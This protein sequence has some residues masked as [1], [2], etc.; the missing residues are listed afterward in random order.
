MRETLTK[1]EVVQEIDTQ[2][3][4]ILK[5]KAEFPVRLGEFE[6]EIK[7][8]TAKY[9]EKKKVWDE[10]D[11]AHRQQL[12]A[13]ELNEDRAKR[14][15]EKLEQIKTNQEFQALTKEIDSLKKHSA[16]IQENAKKASDEANKHKAEL[17]QYETQINEI[18][19]KRD[20]EMA[21]ITEEEKVLD[22]DLRRLEE[23][24]KG[25]IVG[26]DPRYLATYERIRQGRFGIGIAAAADGKCK[27][28]NMRIPPQVYIE[29]QRGSEL[30]L[31]PSCK[32]ILVYKDAPKG[33]AEPSPAS[34]S[35]T[36]TG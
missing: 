15:Q 8:L 26:I 20:A 14:S 36:G 6:T 16:V 5:K 18:K 30:H 22:V 2:I 32:R 27:V 21:K 35:S 17:T 10:F 12:G 31:C 29:I 23:Q 3:G 19:V 28:C 25:S 11:K 34:A 9:D 1:L 4:A 7:A 13:L 33:G 24:R